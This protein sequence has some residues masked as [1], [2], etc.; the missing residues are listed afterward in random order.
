MINVLKLNINHNTEKKNTIV[1]LFHV[2]L[3]NFV[4]DVTGDYAKF[5]RPKVRHRNMSHK[6]E[7]I[8]LK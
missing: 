5:Q 2:V 1:S 6:F 8:Q 4:L 7:M 3:E